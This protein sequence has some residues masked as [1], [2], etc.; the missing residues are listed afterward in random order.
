MPPRLRW[1]CFFFDVFF[2]TASRMITSEQQH[3]HTLFPQS[4][5]HMILDWY[6]LAMHILLW[7]C[8]PNVE[9]NVE[10]W[11]INPTCFNMVFM[12]RQAGLGKRINMI[13]QTVFFKL[14]ALLSSS[15]L[16]VTPTGYKLLPV[17]VPCAKHWKS[18]WQSHMATIRTLGHHKPNPPR[19]FS[20]RF[21][22]FIVI[23]KYHIHKIL[24]DPISRSCRTL[25]KAASR[26]RIKALF[27]RI[28]NAWFSGA[29]MPYEEAVEM[30]K[31]SIKKM[32]G[33][34]AE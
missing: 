15:F 5:T 18:C 29:V 27:S 25:L 23:V 2:G 19:G 28:E 14:S 9:R 10:D 33:K 8:I 21:V 31:K 34:K 30:L 3:R 12:L 6:R 22:S 20:S 16:A 13:M 24:F 17:G 11:V 4:C 32:Y 7:K 1:R 26:V